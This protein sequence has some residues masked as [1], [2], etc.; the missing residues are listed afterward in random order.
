MEIDDAIVQL[1]A[2]L[3]AWLDGNLATISSMDRVAQFKAH[4]HRRRNNQGARSSEGEGSGG[5]HCA[6]RPPGCNR[7][8]TNASRRW[9]GPLYSLPSWQQTLV[10]NWM[11]TNGY[12]QSNRS[13]D[14]VSPTHWTLL[15]LA[16]PPSPC[17]STTPTTGAR[18]RRERTC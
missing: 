8:K 6:V 17:S 15:A 13:H 7:P 12:E 11:D 5:D 3:D 4:S 18:I 2:K 9:S 14:S 10:T 16:G 1:G